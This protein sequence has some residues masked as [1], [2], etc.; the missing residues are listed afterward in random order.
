MVVHHDAEVDGIGPI[1]ALRAFEL[2]DYIPLLD[3]A[4][5]ACD[6]LVVNIEL[7]ELPGEAS[8][9][10]GYPLARLVAQ[11]VADHGFAGRVIV[12]SFDLQAL[13][14]AVAAGVEAGRGAGTQQACTR[15]G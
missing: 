2:P 7:K 3:A 12:S 11:L 10:A 9:D 6:D 1:A 5:E 14:A 15:A 8:Y 13:D 4:I